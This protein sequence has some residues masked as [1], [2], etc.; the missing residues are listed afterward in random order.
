M[1]QTSY[2]SNYM[3]VIPNRARPYAKWEEWREFPSVTD[4][5]GD[6]NL[7]TTLGDQLKWEQIIQQNN[8]QYLSQDLIQASQEALQSFPELAYGYGLQFEEYEGLNYSFHDGSSGAYHATFLRFP[9]YQL[10]VVIMVNSGAV[11]SNYAA[12]QVAKLFIEIEDPVRPEYPGLP[13]NIEDFAKIS[14]LEGHYQNEEGTVIKI[15]Q[16]GDSLYR[17]IYDRKPTALIQEEKAMFQYQS[18]AD[19]KMNF[20]NISKEDQAFTLYLSSQKPAT[21]Y[22]KSDLSFN[23]YDKEALNAR[24]V[25]AETGTE[26]KLQYQE[27][28]RYTLSKNGRARDAQL[29]LA[30]FLL[31]NSYEI[32]ITR[33][34]QGRV[35]GLL[36][37]NGRMQ[38]VKFERVD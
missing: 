7:Y 19:L 12:W 11:P 32:Y 26:I 22:K 27:G 15:V 14:D 8:G 33:D 1:S 6:G 18:L 13:E 34:N 31:M 25:N 23:Q 24:F 36:V 16:R 20:S 10:S 28:D 21:Y 4:I 9:E 30:D 5:H 38:K 17:E 3:E 35:N 2:L 37:N 29:I